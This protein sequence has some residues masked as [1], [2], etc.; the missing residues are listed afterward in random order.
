MY[1]NPNFKKRAVPVQLRQTGDAGDGGIDGQGS[2]FLAQVPVR[3]LPQSRIN[4]KA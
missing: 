4:K 2:R 3:S 1:N